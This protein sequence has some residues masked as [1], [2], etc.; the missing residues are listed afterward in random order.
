MDTFVLRNSRRFAP[1]VLLCLI[2]VLAPCSSAG[3][4]ADRDQ[5]R[6]KRNT[7][8]LRSEIVESTTEADL[9][10][11]GLICVQNKHGA[12]AL[13]VSDVVPGSAAANSGIIAGDLIAKAVKSK[14]IY[15][16][17]VNHQGQIYQT[18]LYGDAFQS[19]SQPDRIYK[20][21]AAVQG[22]HDQYAA[23]PSNWRRGNIGERFAKLWIARYYDPKNSEIRHQLD[24]VEKEL[25]K[26]VK[27][28]GGSWHIVE[29][30]GP[31]TW[32]NEVPD[33]R[34][35]L[36]GGVRLFSIGDVANAKRLFEETLRV[37]RNNPDAYFNLGALSESANKTG[38]A[39]EFYL[40]ART[41]GID[42]A[43]T[44]TNLSAS[45]AVDSVGKMPVL[46]QGGLKEDVS[47]RFQLISR[48][49]HGKTYNNEGTCSLCRIVR[50]SIMSGN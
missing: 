3:E 12:S 41:Y 6:L 1:T 34:Y 43:A 15:Y 25:D 18:S 8:M 29:Y 11:F 17:T 5:T 36:N 50:G 16:L 22:A 37:D 48:Q 35:L 31:A 46:Y 20:A 26:Q 14:S 49:L 47:K 28:N 38:E 13:L 33:P 39:R 27:A 30:F 19:T 9:F 42:N 21:T 45:V 2:F 44:R 7:E 4:A 32:H 40:Q 24:L 10:R 23:L